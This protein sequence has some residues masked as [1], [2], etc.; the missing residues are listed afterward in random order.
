MATEEQEIKVTFK[1]L[2]SKK[3]DSLLLKGYKIS[4]V[5][6]YHPTKHQ[7]CFCTQAG[8]VGWFQGEDQLG[9]VSKDHYINAMSFITKYLQDKYS[10]DNLTAKAIARQISEFGEDYKG[11]K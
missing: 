4:G 7:H 6:L 9:T 3:L 10:I 1:D 11:M 2:S 5:S 8:F